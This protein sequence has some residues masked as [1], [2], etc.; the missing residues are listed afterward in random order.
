MKNLPAKVV[1]LGLCLFGLCS[2][3]GLA[4]EEEATT[5]TSSSS[6]E[7]T[8]TSSEPTGNP[9]AVGTGT[10]GAPTAPAGAVT[11]SASGAPPLQQS[12]GGVGVFSPTPVK[13]S[14]SVLAGYDD[15]VTAGSGG[16]EASEFASGNLALEYAFGEPRLQLALTLG[17]GATYYFSHIST[18]NYDL[19]IKGALGI[20]YKASPRLTLGGSILVAYLTEPS[21]QF[22][23]GLS[24]RNGNYLYT[25]DSAFLEYAW[26]NRFSTKT[27]YG[28][29]AFNYDNNAIGMFS[30]RVS[31][32]F[33]N[34]FR[35]HLVP[36]TTLVAEYRYGIV[37]YDSSFLNSETH[38][39]L[40]GIDHAFNPRFTATLRGGAQFRSY[41]NDGDRTGPYFE[42]TVNYALGRRTALSWVTRYGLEE[43]ETPI[44]QSRTTFRT[45]LT[46]RFNL[47]SR[48]GTAVDLFYVHDDFHAL[49]SSPSTSGAF[50]Q[51]T[52]DGGLT[53]I[54]G[55][56]RLIGLQ[57]GYHYTDVSSDGGFQAYSRNRVFGGVN[58]TF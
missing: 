3:L 34:E 46:T 36:T 10:F 47:T 33:G 56:N 21:F 19:N 20:T 42:T 35:F 8:T 50:T 17:A 27:S 51:D 39:A 25:S 11:G 29:E 24:S 23:G 12:P 7:Q 13:I 38:F 54:Y 41:D 30:N 9:A 55:V 58:V 52:F 16:K 28:F 14:A 6:S 32:T 37:S 44:S 5:T 53:L 26:S 40:A 2:S 18:Q 43:P 45:G 48:V 15:N 22:A 1:S 57:L 4:A 31:N 49:A